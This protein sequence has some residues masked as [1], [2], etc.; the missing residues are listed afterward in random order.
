MRKH[1]LSDIFL[2]VSFVILCM[3]LPAAGA[4]IHR[5]N[6]YETNDENRR[7]SEFPKINSVKDIEEFPS[8]F[9]NWY[10]DHMFLKPSLVKAKNEA[11]IMLFSELSSDDVV[12]GKNKNWLFYR[13]ND[14]QPLET[15][16]RTNLFSEEEL[17]AVVDN[18]IN[19][20]NDVE[21]CGIK[22]VLMIAPDKEQVYGDELMP[23]R[24]KVADNK[25]ITNQLL[26]ALKNADPDFTVVYP[27][28]ALKAGRTEQQL[29]YETDT[30]WNMPGAEIAC[31]ELFNVILKDS[32]GSES[33]QLKA[34]DDI[35]TFAE[36]NVIHRNTYTS[37]KSKLGDLQ[38]LVKLGDKYNST[39]FK[40]VADFER[41]LISEEKDNNNGEVIWEH[42]NSLSESSVP[43]KVYVTGD[44]FR[45]H[46][47]PFIEQTAQDTVITS[48]YYFDTDDLLNEEPDVFVYETAERYIH[49]LG[50]I[51][52]Y[53][54]AALVN[55]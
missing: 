30:H 13:S 28:E 38:K 35:N 24:I 4:V 16:K 43:I 11:D 22:F 41:R 19:L 14:G 46:L 54:T 9:S 2:I 17:E 27:L 49:D 55:N 47:S 23:D 48:R 52:G 31:S 7:L 6:G 29:Y 26:D 40:P 8:S 5:I 37:E 50:M 18:L 36:E 21:D 3:G 10:S 42:Y 32:I 44:S 45:W 20:K 1:K 53:N 12:L 15:Y 25:G 34:L 51:P 39:E 33:N